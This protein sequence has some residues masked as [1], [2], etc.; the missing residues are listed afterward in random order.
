MEKRIFI[1]V[2]ISIAFL[3]AWGYLIP[4]VF[5]EV[6]QQQ[7]RAQ[8]K[9]PQASPVP[10]SSGT[11]A[12]ST[13]ADATTTSPEIPAAAAPPTALA[14]IAAE[15]LQQTVVETTLYTARFTNRGA[16]LVSFQLKEYREADGQLV[17]LV[18]RRGAERSDFP[19]SIETANPAITRAANESYY[20]LEDTAGRGSRTL[21]YRLVTPQGASVEKVFTFNDRSYLFGFD[22]SLTGRAVPYRAVIGPGIRT[23][24][25][26]AK[27]TQFLQTGNGFYQADD[28]LEVIQRED[29]KSLQR[30]GDVK[31]VGVEDN[32]FLSTLLPKVSSEG[33]LRSVEFPLPDGK[34]KR[35]EVYAGLNAEG[36][37]VSGSAFFGPKKAEI[38]EQYGLDRTLKLGMFGFIA[39]LLLTALVW[40]YGITANYGWAIVIL[41]VIIKIILY[42]LQHK[43]IVSMKKMQQVQ[44]KVNAIKD[45]YKKAKTDPE[46][47]NKMN[48]EMMKL[49]QQEG[50]NPMS[51]CLP[52][53]LQLP[54]LWA[55][56][57]LLSNAIE[58]RGAEFM[59]WITD[60]S[61]KDPYYITPILMTATM[62]IQQWMTPTTAD[63][64][65]RRIF[66]MMPLIFG[67]IFKD[68]PS[69][70]VLYWL[71][72]NVLSI[73][74]QGIMNKYWKEHPVELRTAKE[75]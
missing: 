5:P 22:I 64:M 1:A 19:F 29:A 39:R 42:P 20:V 28:S 6:A 74:Q 14:P 70:L 55:F 38:L 41:T 58:L 11:A 57:S 18:K 25:P 9:K 62:F 26:T 63:P 10:A 31:F 37:R 15:R 46:Q 67:F 47:R 43:S 2:M 40:L 45:K 7:Q 13:S 71:V 66:L 52:I 49:Y 16:Q 34:E 24:D 59:A 35:R 69:G 60:L 65:Q 68:F 21:K 17:D 61:L 8:T 12:P 48:V 54:I 53:L 4:R 33:L 3:W 27:D 72:Q 50:I 56:Y 32:Y 73:I 30:L 51:G 23:A 75:R 36:G 44:P